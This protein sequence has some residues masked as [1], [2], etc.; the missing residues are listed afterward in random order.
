MS[1]AIT[2][3][4]DEQILYCRLWK[5]L[6]VAELRAAN[7]DLDALLVTASPPVHLVFHVTDIDER[8]PGINAMRRPL[9]T[10]GRDRIGWAV[11]ADGNAAIRFI[12]L[13]IC[14]SLGLRVHSSPS[15]EEAAAF[16]AT[17]DPALPAEVLTEL[18]RLA[19]TAPGQLPHEPVLR[20]R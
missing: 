7:A 8:L 1:Y 6:R 15:V 14:R 4:G 16:L 17:A 9:T 2:W 3:V 20:V 12:G 13:V 11:F 10:R 5:S 19:A 18:K